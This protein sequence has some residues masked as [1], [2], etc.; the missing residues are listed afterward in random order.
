MRSRRLDIEI[1]SKDLL[2]L[3]T[4]ESCASSSFKMS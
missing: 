3:M 4:S 2:E 1:G